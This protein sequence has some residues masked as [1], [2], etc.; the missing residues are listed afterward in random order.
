MA[1]TG[2]CNANGSLQ[3][4]GR[5]VMGMTWTPAVH[6]SAS[7]RS[8]SVVTAPSVVRVSSLSV[9]TPLM[10]RLDG[11]GQL[12]SGFMPDRPRSLFLGAQNQAPAYAG[13]GIRPLRGPQVQ[14]LLQVGRGGGA[15]RAGP[16][17]GVA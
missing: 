14:R 16:G 7:A 13:S 8:T 12:A 2:H 17:I 5:P 11:A 4:T 6:S 10:A 1:S 9:K 3:P 15:G